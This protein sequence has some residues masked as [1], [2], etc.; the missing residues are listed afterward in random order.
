MSNH[1]YNDEI[2]F[3]VYGLPF[4]KLKIAGGEVFT[5]KE[6]LMHNKF[7]IIDER[8]II[9][10]S[11]NWTNKANKENNENIVIIKDD[12]ELA[13]QLRDLSV[14]KKL[15]SSQIAQEMGISRSTVSKHLKRLGV[16][17]ISVGTVVEFS[18]CA[19]GEREAAAETVTGS[20]PDAT[21]IRRN[22]R[23]TVIV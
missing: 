12:I 13:S 9:T 7:C 14:R 18:A 20:D 8:I 4:T 23:I 22:T 5:A 16:P 15:T 11:Y 2:N 19:Y 6:N 1:I 17:S 3:G 10:G 21:P